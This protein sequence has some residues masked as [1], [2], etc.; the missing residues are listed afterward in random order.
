MC[1]RAAKFNK[2]SYSKQI[3]SFNSINSYANLVNFQMVKLLVLRT[4][5]MI[6]RALTNTFHFK[7]SDVLPTAKGA[8]ETTKQVNT[9]SHD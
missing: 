4:T 3:K 7:R 6:P 5:T 1:H 2:L 8:N 9:F